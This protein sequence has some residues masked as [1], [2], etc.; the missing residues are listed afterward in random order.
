MHAASVPTALVMSGLV[1]I[2]LVMRPQGR[3]LR[4][5][6]WVNIRLA[7]ACAIHAAQHDLAGR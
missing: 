7:A 6:N 3:V 1:I 4:V 5:L 2:G